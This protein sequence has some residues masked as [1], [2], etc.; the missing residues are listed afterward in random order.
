LQTLSQAQQE[1]AS[2]PVIHGEQ[3]RRISDFL[4][5]V[6]SERAAS[7]IFRNR[8]LKPGIG[9]AASDQLARSIGQAA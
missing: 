1:H 8:A 4:S 2:W 5:F 7:S 6:S 9:R 3:T